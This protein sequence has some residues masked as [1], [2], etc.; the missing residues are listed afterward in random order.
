[1]KN[2]AASEG[3]CSAAA[4]YVTITEEGRLNKVLQRNMQN[5]MPNYSTSCL[6]TQ[7]ELEGTILQLMIR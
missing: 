7:Q 5:F 6:L 2:P 1:M 4:D 3:D